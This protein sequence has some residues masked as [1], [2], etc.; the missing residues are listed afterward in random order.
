M[1]F[2]TETREVFSTMEPEG[3]LIT[4][5]VDQ[6]DYDASN[7]RYTITLNNCA[8]VNAEEDNK[9]TEHIKLEITD[10]SKIVHVEKGKFIPNQLMKVSEEDQKMAEH[11][12]IKTHFHTGSEPILT[13]RDRWF[14]IFWALYIIA[15]VLVFVVIEG[16]TFVSA[17]YFRIVTSFGVGYGDFYPRT[18]MGKLLNC[19][20]IVIDLAKLAYIDWRI[21]SLL[22]KYRQQKF[23]F[24]DMYA[25][26]PHPR[27]DRSSNLEESMFAKIINHRNLLIYISL[28]LSLFFVSGTL[29]M[30]LHEGHGWLE[31]LEWNFVTLSQVGYGNT[32]PR[33][34]TGQIFSIFYI[35]LGYV[36]L[37][38]LAV[39]IFDKFMLKMMQQDT[40]KSIN[41]RNKIESVGL[42]SQ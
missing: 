21:L 35:I 10:R 18:P 20:F 30:C 12:I 8:V 1:M 22:F 24:E 33:T 14:L 16:D 40:Q 28:L 36:L 25:S 13:T 26:T 6:L 42:L 38:S 7:D 41:D 5:R 17:F 3:A 2:H 9:E 37:L 15:A 11:N 23:A 29:V 31:G 34:P 27:F 32:V 19:L 39:I 4:L